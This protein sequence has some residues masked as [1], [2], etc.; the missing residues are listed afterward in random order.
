MRKVLGISGQNKQDNGGEEDQK[1]RN[2]GGRSKPVEF[3]KMRLEGSSKDNFKG[4]LQNPS[5][6]GS[7]S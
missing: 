1:S 6:K 5:T 4:G 2:I 3:E 7:K